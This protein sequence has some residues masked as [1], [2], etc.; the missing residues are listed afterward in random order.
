[1]KEEGILVE[2]RADGIFIIQINRPSKRN[3]IDSHHARLLFQAIK[4]FEASDS[5][6][7]IL[8][9]KGDFCT[10]F[11]LKEASSHHYN[12]EQELIMEWQPNS[13]GRGP[14]GPTRH[15]PS[16][17]II[18]AVTGYC[19]AGGLELALWCDLIVSHPG[20]TFGVFC[21]KVGVPLIDGGTIRL[22][23]IIGLNRAREMILTGRE[24]LGEEAY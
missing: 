7:A 13:S 8:Y 14:M 5:K 23:A 2:K 3:A 6:V 1:M 17:P 20:G 10:G 22:S 11:D 21:R 18:A 9:G 19:V 24:V 12:A 15:F 4:D 16:K